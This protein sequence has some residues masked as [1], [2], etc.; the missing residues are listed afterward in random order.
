M[1]QRLRQRLRIVWFWVVWF[2]S[3]WKDATWVYPTTTQDC[4]ICGEYR[5][6]ALDIIARN[7]VPRCALCW[8]NYHHA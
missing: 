7:Y 6:C 5:L 3:V 1:I 2:G 8:R 4:A